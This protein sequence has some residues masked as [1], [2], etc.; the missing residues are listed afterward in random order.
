MCFII[1]IF[2]I[3][4]NFDFFKVQKVNCVNHEHTNEAFG[5][6]EGLT[7]QNTERK[8]KN[9]ASG[10]HKEVILTILLQAK[11]VRQRSKLR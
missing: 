5:L 8:P 4:Q 11:C 9:E 1:L 6:N 10:K 2:K 3:I 7:V